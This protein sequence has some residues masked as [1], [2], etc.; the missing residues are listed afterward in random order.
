MM[1]SEG[2]GR[3]NKSSEGMRTPPSFV[4]TGS[5]TDKLRLWRRQVVICRARRGLRRLP[6]GRKGEKER[7]EGEMGRKERK[8]KEVKKRTLV[9]TGGK[10]K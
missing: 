4:I 9:W 10:R 7:W 5:L 3:E 8:L 1:K 2:N 6:V